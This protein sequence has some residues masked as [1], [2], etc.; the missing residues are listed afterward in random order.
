MSRDP[1]TDHARSAAQCDEE[2]V[3]GVRPVPLRPRCAASSEPSRPRDDIL[4]V[5]LASL[6]RTEVY[7]RVLIDQFELARNSDLVT[8]EDVPSM[9]L[10]ELTGVSD[11]LQGGAHRTLLRLS[12]DLA[13]NA[14]MVADLADVTSIE[15]AF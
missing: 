1:Q 10:V 4:R 15:P 3:T 12:A 6:R 2:R 14:R 5:A 11:T 13:R 9:T 8:L 7:A